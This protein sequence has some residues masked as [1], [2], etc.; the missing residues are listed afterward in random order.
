MPACRL[1]KKGISPAAPRGTVN[2]MVCVPV[3]LTDSLTFRGLTG[4]YAAL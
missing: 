3:L 2:S 4:T 1:Q